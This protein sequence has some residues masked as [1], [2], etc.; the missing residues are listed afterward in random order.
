M[1]TLRLTFPQWQGADPNIMTSLVPELSQQDAAQGYYI[2]SQLLEW[3]APKSQAKQAT[4]PVSLQYSGDD[5]EVEQGI[6]AYQ[7][8]S[9]QLQTA[10]DIIRKYNPEKIVTL[11]GECSVSV[12]PFSYLAEKYQNDIAVIWI[13]A[14]PDLTLPNEGYIG[15]HAMALSALAGKG[16]KYIVSQLP[17]VIDPKNAA[18]IGFRSH[19]QDN[20]RVKN[21]GVQK[22]QCRKCE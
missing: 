3:L 17:A 16:D 14:H 19:E 6:Y 18:I 10:F 20:Q 7:A 4:V 8:I 11:G 12:A 21:F 13:D 15:Y 22:N 9:R 2:G 5:V 1:T